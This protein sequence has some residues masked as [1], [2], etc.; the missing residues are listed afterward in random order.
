MISMAMSKTYISWAPDP[1]APRDPAH[2]PHNPS[3]QAMRLPPPT[4]LISVSR[5]SSQLQTPQHQTRPGYVY[6]GAYVLACTGLD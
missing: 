3:G 4:S 6:Q 5:G 1:Y 2:H